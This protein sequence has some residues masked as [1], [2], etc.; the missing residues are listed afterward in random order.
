MTSICQALWRQREDTKLR[1]KA[2]K[3]PIL[4]KF[5]VL[6]FPGKTKKDYETLPYSTVGVLTAFCLSSIF[7]LFACLFQMHPHA[8]S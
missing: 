5:I 7:K 4:I 3:T 6:L 8:A 2:R 1:K